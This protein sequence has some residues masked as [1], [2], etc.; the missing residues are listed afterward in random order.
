MGGLGWTAEEQAVCN[1]HRGDAV[2]DRE[3]NTIPDASNAAAYLAMVSNVGLEYFFVED[4]SRPQVQV[5]RKRDRM[6]LPDR[7]GSK[8]PAYLFENLCYSVTAPKIVAYHAEFPRYAAASEPHRHNG[9]ELVYVLRGKLSIVVEDEET[10]LS[11]GDAMYFDSGAAHTNRQHG[12]SAQRLSL[13]RPANPCDESKQSNYDKG[14]RFGALGRLYSPRYLQRSR[15]KVA[16][17]GRCCSEQ[18]SRGGTPG[19]TSQLESAR[20]IWF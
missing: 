5:I 7:P 11:H 19:S 3:G 13:P 20:F 17:C 6:R 14:A 16:W 2:E 4:S 18:E 1:S 10:I 12:H 8:S 15:T 9:A